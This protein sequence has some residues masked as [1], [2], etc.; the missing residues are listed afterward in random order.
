MKRSKKAVKYQGFAL[1]IPLIDEIKKFIKDDSNYRSVT[2][3]VREALREKL[4]A[5]KE[6]L[7]TMREVAEIQKQHSKGLFNPPLSKATRPFEVDEK[8][9][10]ELE[11]KV[12]K[13][14]ELLEKKKSSNGNGHGL[15]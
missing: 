5:D 8:R 13:I 3:Y 12:N 10:E 7:V 15:E 4:K 9:I 2:D 6:A 11:S 1:E 14:L